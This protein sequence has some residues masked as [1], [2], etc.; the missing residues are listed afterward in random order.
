MLNEIVS[1]FTFL[2]FDYEGST[3]VK[4]G[5]VARVKLV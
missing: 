3:S 1:I 2:P 4:E 5:E